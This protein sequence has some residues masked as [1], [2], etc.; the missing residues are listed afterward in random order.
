MANLVNKGVALRVMQGEEF[1]KIYKL[2]DLLE[3][4]G[5]RLL[6]IGRDDDDISNVIPIKETETSYISR[7]HCTLEYN[8]I[9]NTWLLRDGQWDAFTNLKWKVST[10]GT[11]VGS[12]EVSM[13]GIILNIGDIISIGDVKLRVEGY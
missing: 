8:Q 1:G 3:S 12:K 4:V 2:N 13:N 7:K 9:N 11:F 5:K 10:N 6:T